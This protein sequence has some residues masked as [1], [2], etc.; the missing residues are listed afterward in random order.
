MKSVKLNVFCVC[1]RIT[2]RS[3][4]MSAFLQ[5]MGK[6]WFMI[7]LFT[8]LTIGL[9]ACGGADDED[10]TIV[11]AAPEWQSID[12]H[13]AV[14]QIIAEEGYGYKT[15][16]LPGSSPATLQGLRDGEIDVYM[17]TWIENFKDQYDAGIEEGDII[18]LSTNFDDNDQ[19]LY[20]PT[21]M[22]E[23]DEERGIEPMAPD[24]QSVADLDRKSVV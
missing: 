6:K 22:I 1:K 16:R 23:G 2:W 21:Y 5:K 3:Y 13:N 24:L 9:T 8:V 12:F 4:F 14:A 11:F 7:G 18:E 15:D 10:Q 20:V 17:E 19:G